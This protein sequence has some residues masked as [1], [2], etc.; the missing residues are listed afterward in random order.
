[1]ALF[2]YCEQFKKVGFSLY[3]RSSV[4]FEESRRF[5]GDCGDRPR[6]IIPPGGADFEV[7]GHLTDLR[8]IKFNI[9]SRDLCIFYK[10]TSQRPPSAAEHIMCSNLAGNIHRD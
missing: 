10:V 2:S 8:A 9:E 5:E 6:N 4:F 1:M 7:G 3:Q